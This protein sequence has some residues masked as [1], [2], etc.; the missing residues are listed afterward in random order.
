LATKIDKI[1]I[2]AHVYREQGITIADS[3]KDRIIK[4]FNPNF[5]DYGIV[6]AACFTSA[7]IVAAYSTGFMLTLTILEFSILFIS[8]YLERKYVVA[9]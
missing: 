9:E 2:I 6:T 3:L 1:N 4:Q 5:S 8:L 7:T